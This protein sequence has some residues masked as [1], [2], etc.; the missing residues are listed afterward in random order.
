MKKFVFPL[1]CA[2][3]FW[4]P[5]CFLNFRHLTLKIPPMVQKKKKK[6][7]DSPLKTWKKKKKKKK[8]QVPP[9]NA[10]SLLP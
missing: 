5:P 2:P 3:N 8:N 6:K 1:A 10:H 9:Q 7:S 4:D